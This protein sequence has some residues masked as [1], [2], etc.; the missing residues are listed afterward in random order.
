MTEARYM[1][2]AELKDEDGMVAA[3]A[4]RWNRC[5]LEN[6]VPEAV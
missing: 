6:T 5:A 1:M 2:A 3:C 4:V